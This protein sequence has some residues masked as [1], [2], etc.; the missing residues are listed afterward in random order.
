MTTPEKKARRRWK[1]IAAAY[2]RGAAA[3]REDQRG[4]K[5]TKPRR[6]WVYYFGLVLSSSFLTKTPPFKEWPNW[7]WL[8]LLFLSVPLV[9]TWQRRRVEAEEH[10]R[11]TPRQ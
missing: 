4:A 5:M 10:E 3:Q 6:S 11:D 8:I 9:A 7:V 2:Q 1:A